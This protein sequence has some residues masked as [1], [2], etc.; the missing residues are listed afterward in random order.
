M[1]F[2]KSL[3]GF[4]LSVSV[5]VAMLL[6][7]AELF[8]QAASTLITMKDGKPVAALATSWKRL[9]AGKY[10]FQL[11]TA[12]KVGRDAALTPA[13]VKSSLESRMGKSNGVK[14]T[15]KGAAAVE[16]AFTGDEAA[17]LDGVSKTRIR[18]SKQVELALQ[19]GVSSGGLRANPTDRPANDN[20][21]KATVIGV[22]EGVITARALDVGKGVTGLKVQDTIKFKAGS[23]VTKV[24]EIIFIVPDKHD[25]GMWMTKSVS[26][27]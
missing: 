20:E 25:G 11:N 9:G 26:K 13:L 22:K 12:A 14:V 16:V 2:R 4:L 8:A 27:Q 7:G 1:S 21:V 17:F 5:V 6:S 19:S 15:P 10:E 24:N 3:S 18:A 23:L